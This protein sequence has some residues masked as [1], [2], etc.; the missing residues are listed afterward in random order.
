MF[1]SIARYYRII[2]KNKNYAQEA[3][4]VHTIIGKYLHRNNL[5]L[6]DLGCGI[7]RH[8]TEFA[9]LGYTVTGVDRSRSMLSQARKELGI[10]HVH[11]KLLQSSIQRLKLP[12]LFDVVV[13]LFHVLSYQLEQEDAALFFS[14][15]YTHLKSGGLFIFDCWYGPGVLTD[16]PKTTTQTYKD[17][18]AVI[19]RKKTPI[20]NVH[21]NQVS[22]V[23]TVTV[24]NGKKHRTFSETH[25]LRYFFYPEIISLLQQA[26]FRLMAWGELGT[27]LNKAGD[28]SWSVLFVCQKP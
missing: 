3:L 6:L 27:A 9:R 24:H 26:G 14:Q 2:Y 22:V 23:H 12:S 4:A 18:G 5:S 21:A 17:A 28:K 1:T 16:K 8:I 15:A 13:S 25:T 20:M 19:Q 7:G 11:A 10:R